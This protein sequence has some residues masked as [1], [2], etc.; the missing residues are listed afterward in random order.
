MWALSYFSSATALA[1]VQSLTA[2]TLFQQEKIS[3]LTDPYAILSAHYVAIGGLERL[4]NEKTSY[5]RGTIRFAEMDGELQVWAEGIRYRREVDYPAFSQIEGDNGSYMWSVDL[6]NKQL[7]YKDPETLKRRKIRELLEDFEN[8]N[9]MSEYFE[10]IFKGIDD[11]NGEQCYVIETRN[12]INR[13]VYYDYFSIETFRLLRQT[14]QEPYLKI[15]THYSDFRTLNE[16]TYAFRSETDISPT[17]KN[18]LIQTEKLSINLPVKQETFALPEKDVRDFSFDNTFNTEAIPFLFVENTI[19]LPVALHG[20]T[21]YW[22]LDSGADMSVIDADYAN[23]LGLTQK[24][25]LLGNATNSLA[26]FSFVNL[27]AYQ[28]QG[29][30][31]YDQTILSYKG[32]ASKFYE[33]EIVGIL[34][35]DFLSRFITKVDYSK[36]HVSF[37]DPETF[38]YKGQGHRID[39]PLQNRLFMLPMR[40]NE[41]FDGR[42]GLDLGSF[43]VTMNYRFASKHGFLEKTGIKRLSSDISGMFYEYQI[44]TQSLELA[45]YQVRNE[46]MSF[47][48][49]EGIG[50]NSNEELDGLI[51]NTL[52]RH[53]T[54]YLDYKNQQLIFEKGEN[55]DHGFPVDKSGM[56]IGLSPNNQTQIFLVVDNTPAHD[57]G[58]LPGDIILGINDLEGESLPSIVK[59]KHMFQAESGTDYT[60][61]L[62][63]DKQKIILP[64]RLKDLYE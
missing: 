51:G 3:K 15:T 56:T 57:G 22:V 19:F 26:E 32:L 17:G 5:M 46:L 27:A 20:E 25:V 64:I 6:N 1:D 43:D 39:A 52:L 14:I 33:P 48:L 10:L 44:K 54:L 38:V 37:Y 12:T 24:G 13:D 42:F 49:A 11:V 40:V 61:K 8:F 62:L 60:L 53:F 50:T 55:F 36:R 34:G 23:R 45:G 63:R 16:M 7:V 35:Y 47:P 29:L 9:P 30:K 2:K 31:L 41:T 21:H 58:F 18:I 59:L 4:K 28:V